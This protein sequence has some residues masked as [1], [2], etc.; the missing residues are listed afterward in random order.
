MRRIVAIFFYEVSGVYNPEEIE[1]SVFNGFKTA[2]KAY[3]LAFLTEF[4]HNFY[5]MDVLGR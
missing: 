4:F 3:R 5:N 2:I 1:K